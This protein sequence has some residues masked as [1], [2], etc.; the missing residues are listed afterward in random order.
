VLAL[1]DKRR[2]TGSVQPLAAF[3]TNPGLGPSSIA[4]GPIR[5]VVQNSAQ[6][7]RRYLVIAPGARE[8]RGVPFRSGLP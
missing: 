3:M 6:A 1:A 4:R 5:Q 8:V 2:R 7:E